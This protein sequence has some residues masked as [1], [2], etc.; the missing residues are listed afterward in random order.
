MLA[1]ALIER[2]DVAPLSLSHFF[3][4]SS[5]IF[6][7]RSS[8]SC[9]LLYSEKDRPSLCATL[10]ATA[11]GL[12]AFPRLADRLACFS[13]LLDCVCVFDVFSLFSFQHRVP[14]FQPALSPSLAACLP[15][16]GAL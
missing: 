13:S 7:D 1:T 10:V 8:I 16:S 15:P 12:W 3:H 4:K 2:I 5:S 14:L 11:S 6:S 9:Y